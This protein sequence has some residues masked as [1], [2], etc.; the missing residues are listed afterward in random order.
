MLLNTAGGLT[1]GDEIFT[2]VEWRTRAHAVVTSQAAERIYRSRGGDARIETALSVGEAATALWLPQE[3]ILFDGARL[4]RNT[5]VALRGSSSFLAVESLVFGRR[6]MRETVRAGSIV[7]DWRIELDGKLVFAD[8]LRISD[9]NAPLDSALAE[10]ACANGHAAIAT[11][12]Y[13]ASHCHRHVDALRSAIAKK[14][15][16][17]GISCLGPLLN[18]RLL[19]PTGQALREA[20]VSLFTTLTDD[21]P[22][23]LPRVWQI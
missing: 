22:D 11:M 3:T 1:D 9:E 6:A 15:I 13:A 4:Q 12:I 19:A 8:R 21:G 2:S 18:I 5:S 17:G 16:A 14:R 20:I 10:T 23:T 7:D